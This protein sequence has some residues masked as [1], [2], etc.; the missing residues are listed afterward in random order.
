MTGVRWRVQVSSTAD[1][2][3]AAMLDDDSVETDGAK[4]LY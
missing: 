4:T 1:D 3:A 2:H